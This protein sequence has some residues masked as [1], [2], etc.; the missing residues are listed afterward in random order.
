M[1]PLIEA[2]VPTNL[3]S[4]S[5]KHVGHKLRIVGTCVIYSLTWWKHPDQPSMIGHDLSRDLLL[6]ADR[7]MHKAI[8]VDASIVIASTGKLPWLRGGKATLMASGYF[9]PADVCHL[10]FSMLVTSPPFM[11]LGGIELT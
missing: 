1:A 5:N 8:L 3:E 9:E 7:N 4:I 10:L 6:L 11:R 2:A